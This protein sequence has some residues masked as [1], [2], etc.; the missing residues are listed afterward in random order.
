MLVI[1]TNVVL[2]LWV[3]SDPVA[4]A[5][6]GALQD[7]HWQWIATVPMR[8][9]LLRVLDY[10]HIARRLAASQRTT[11][12]VIECFDALAHIQPPSPKAS[13]TCKDPDD[14]KF[15]DLA[16]LHR[17]PLLSKDRAVLQMSKRLAALGVQARSAPA[18][19]ACQD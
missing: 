5:L 14:Q 3:F 9:E 8:S 11:Q 19:S 13:V 12:K 15:I 17:C 1:D 6:A 4:Q 18:L 16:V 2:D 10:P 7:G